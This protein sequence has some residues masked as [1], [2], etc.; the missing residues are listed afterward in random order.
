MEHVKQPRTS[1]KLIPIMRDEDTSK[2]LA[3]CRGKSFLQVR[4]EA[5]IR[6]LCNTGARLSEVGFLEVEDFY[7]L[8]HSTMARRCRTCGLPTAVAGHWPPT[9]SRSWLGDADWPPD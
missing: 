9:G 8:G 3:A 2:V 5:I 7:G 6:L 1:Q 4:D